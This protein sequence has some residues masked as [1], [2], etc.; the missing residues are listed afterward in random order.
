MPIILFK[1][2]IH[3]VQSVPVDEGAGYSTEL[4]SATN[5]YSYVSSSL[6]RRIGDVGSLECWSKMEVFISTKQPSVIIRSGCA[7]TA[8]WCI[9]CNALAVKKVGQRCGGVVCPHLLAESFEKSL[10]ARRVLLSGS[11][12]VHSAYMMMQIDA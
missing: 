8:A 6:P 5:T 2:F 7:K 9:L 11:P 1:R 10:G 3:C 12:L 4:G